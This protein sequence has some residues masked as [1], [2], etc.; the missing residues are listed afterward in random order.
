MPTRTV[1]EILGCRDTPIAQL[2]AAGEKEVLL[3]D[4]MGGALTGTCTGGIAAAAGAP[5]L[6]AMLGGAVTGACLVGF[7]NL[8]AIDRN[9]MAAAR[10]AP[11]PIAQEMRDDY[12]ALPQGEEREVANLA[13]DSLES[14]ATC[15]ILF[16]C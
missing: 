13:N 2:S 1:G 10:G 15:G 3:M 7:F 5:A 4:S 9:R 16:C 8:E 11:A 14:P 12:Q 6:P